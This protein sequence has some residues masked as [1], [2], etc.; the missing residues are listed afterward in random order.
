MRLL[1]KLY[2]I[3]SPSFGEEEIS[4]FVIKVLQELNVSDF[5]VFKNQIYNLIPDTPLLCAH[6]DQ[7]GGPISRVVIHNDR[8]WGNGNLGADDKNGVWIILK[9][10]ERRRDFSFIFSTGEEAGG[11]VQELLDVKESEI[12]QLKYGLVF[13]RR[14]GSDVIAYSNDYCTKEFQA[15]VLDIAAPFGYKESVGIFSD[16]DSISEYL[17]CVNLS[18]GYYEPHTN[19]EYTKIPE[20]YNALEL[21]D[22]LLSSLTK[23]YKKPGKSYSWYGH[24]GSGYSNNWSKRRYYQYDDYDLYDYPQDKV[25]YWCQS[26]DSSMELDEAY[27]D[28]CPYCGEQLIIVDMTGEEGQ[29][30]INTAETVLLKS[31]S[32]IDEDDII[33]YGR[34]CISC[35]CWASPKTI[36]CKLCAGA[37]EEA[38]LTDDGI[39]VF[40]DEAVYIDV[41]CP[42]C[43]YWGVVEADNELVCRECGTSLITSEDNYFT[44][45]GSV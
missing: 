18:C 37:T 21:G 27:Q 30:E 25:V 14:G 15:D 31:K 23:K 7:V 3:H 29:T 39:V 5:S 6:M 20:L 13:D 11:E 12:E 34:Y 33:A 10:L 24:M 28:I 19:E 42:K 22:M 40:D 43:N 38:V 26:C 32:E 45:E 16:C 41:Y 35:D 4:K 36:A 2:M 9:L 8:I 1:S 17:S 44:G